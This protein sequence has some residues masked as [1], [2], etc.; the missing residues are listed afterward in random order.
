[1]QKFITEIMAYADE[2]KDLLIKRGWLEQPPLSTDRES[3]Y[4]N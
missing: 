2:G 3:L 4:K 1:M